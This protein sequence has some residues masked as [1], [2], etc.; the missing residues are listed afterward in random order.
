MNPVFY[1]IEASGFD[2]YPI[3]VG[4]AWWDAAKHDIC[5]EAH[6]IK[7]DAV[8]EIDQTWDQRAEELHGISLRQLE[9]EGEPTLKIAQRMNAALAGRDLYA[10][11]PYDETWLNHLFDSA[12]LETAFTLHQTS[13]DILI[14]QQ[15][16]K[17]RHDQ[18]ALQNIMHQAAEAAPHTHRA[19][20]DARHLAVLWQGVMSGIIRHLSISSTGVVQ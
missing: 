13:A 1:D 18:V 8:W 2:G 3:E 17:L 20:A 7:P 6:L 10:T 16:R 19:E 11:S 12:G 5:S 9:Q 4:W 14:M 15:A